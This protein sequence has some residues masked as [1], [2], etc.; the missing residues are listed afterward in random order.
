MI[1]YFDQAKLML[2][3]LPI[4]GQEEAFALK[5]GTALNFFYFDMPRLSVDLDLT[6]LPIKP[7]DESLA[8]ITASLNRISDKIKSFFP[9]NQVQQIKL[10][11]TDY[12]YKLIVSNGDSLV[13]IEPN[14]ILRGSCYPP[15]YKP[16][17]QKACEIFKMEMDIRVLSLADLYGGKICAA[18]DRQHPR[19]LFDM[20][21]L[22]ETEGL[23]EHICQ[24]FVVYLASHNRPMAELLAP[25]FQEFRQLYETEFKGMTSIDVSYEALATINRDLAGRI[26]TNLSDNERKFLLSVKTGSPDFGLL[27][28]SGIETFPAIR[29]KV[30]N[31]LKMK[32][33]KKMIAVEK[34]KTIL[35]G[36]QQ[37]NSTGEPQ[38]E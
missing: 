12:I 6:F 37:E 15:I 32:P 38:A 18:L 23:N 17:C 2:T 8:D 16:L 10:K 13:K 3:V 29:W 11:D 33:E 4:V 9:N 7:R 27:S 24:A 1:K 34:L 36:F 28:I 5:G 22:F 14:M 26:L 30:E 20:K 21:L 25:N 35:Y 31:I 19:D